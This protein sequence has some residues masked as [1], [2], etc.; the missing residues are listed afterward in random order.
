MT[1]TV[2]LLEL[3]PDAGIHLP[4]YVHTPPEQDSELTKRM[5]LLYNP[6]V[7]AQIPVTDQLLIDVLRT[8]SNKYPRRIA[9]DFFGA[10]TT[11]RELG[12]NVQ[13]TSAL[14]LEHGVKRGDRVSIVA[15]NCPQFVYLLYSCLQLGVVC[16]LHN[17]LAAPTELKWQ[18]ENAES[19]LVFV[20]QKA[21]VSVTELVRSMDTEVISLDVSAALPRRLRFALHLPI[22]QAKD[23]YHQLCDPQAKD[24]PD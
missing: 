23:L 1:E 8:Q 2:D 10:T 16:V 19:K 7:P 14:L 22:K 9:L 24:L 13:R 5:R 21:A 11:Y 20:W 3:A 4:R 12:E 17:P 6:D 18:I 15:P